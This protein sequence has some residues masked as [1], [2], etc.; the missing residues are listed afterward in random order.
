MLSQS[1]Y[2]K[3]KEA[4][5]NETRKAY[6]LEVR[7]EI[8]KAFKMLEEDSDKGTWNG[9]AQGIPVEVAHPSFLP[10]LWKALSDAGYKVKLD[11]GDAHLDSIEAFDPLEHAHGGLLVFPMHGCIPSLNPEE[12]DVS[13]LDPVK[14]EEE[15][16]KREKPKKK[17]G[18]SK[19]DKISFPIE[20]SSEE[21]EEEEEEEAEDSDSPKKKKK[22]AKRKRSE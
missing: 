15:E 21:E 5:L 8:R 20:S 2:R 10:Y 4:A 13:Q 6:A 1:K 16:E 17:E 19:K 12:L 7:E 11:T 9:V 3:T 18:K 22:E 14:D